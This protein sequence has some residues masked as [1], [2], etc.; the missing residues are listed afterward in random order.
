MGNDL[1]R[2]NRPKFS[3]PPVVEV[4]AIAQF[5]E[6]NEKAFFLNVGKLWDK[7]GKESFPYLEYKNKAPSLS[8]ESGGVHLELIKGESDFQFPRIWLESEDKGFVMQIQS[9]RLSLSWRELDR[10]SLSSY[11]SYE[12]VWASFSNSMRQL[13]AFAEEHCGSALEVNFLHLAYINVIPFSDFGGAENIHKCIP[14]VS[15][16]NIPSYLGTSEA[17]NFLWDIPIKQ[18]G[19]RFKIQG[20]T[21]AD[22]NTGD[23]LLR[24]DLLQRGVVGISL[25]EEFAA[26]QSWFDEAHLNIV[27]TFQDVTSD[28]MHK[29]KWGIE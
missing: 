18:N 26:M 21:G 12:R 10:E 2:K 27:N 6:L 16:E 14:S 8:H 22:N 4:V 3:N 7:L 23:R 28:Y 11:S 15:S 1:S 20:V 9:D 24:L 13:S 25:D 19:S 29:E 17:I 5:S